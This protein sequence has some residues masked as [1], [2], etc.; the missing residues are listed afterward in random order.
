M[1]FIKI[2]TAVTAA[3]VS[4]YNIN[5]TPAKLGYIVPF[6]LVH[7]GKYKQKTN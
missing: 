3:C 5:G 7:A 1:D 2:Y 6:T 4:E